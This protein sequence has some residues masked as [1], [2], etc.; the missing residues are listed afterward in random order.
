MAT[1]ASLYLAAV[2]DGFSRRVLAWRLSITLAADFCIEALEEALARH[3]RPPRSPS[4]GTASAL[5]QRQRLR[6][7]PLAD[8]QTRGGVSARLR[9]RRRSAASIAR[10]P[11]FCNGTRPHSSPG[12][13][14]PTRRIPASRR[15]S[16]RRR[17]Q[18]G[19]PPGRSPEAVQTNR[20]S[21]IFTAK[22]CSTKMARGH[23]TPFAHPDL[24]PKTRAIGSWNPPVI[25][26][27]GGPPM[28]C[29]RFSEE[30]IIG[31]LKEHG[32]A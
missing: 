15:Q 10:Y 17:N 1:N 21:S 14:A 2:I 22:Y 20:A 29:S 9:Q 11:G 24:S 8:G 32:E 27:A 31:V 28:K 19:D 25:D 6:R 12:G 30:Q 26:D 18:G 16:R 23:L 5:G 7:A 13:Q 4:A 3:G